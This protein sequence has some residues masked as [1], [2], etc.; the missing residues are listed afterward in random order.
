IG[1][2]PV[3]ITDHGDGHRDLK[4]IELIEISIVESPADL[5]ATI[6]DVKSAIAEAM[7]LKEIEALLRDAG[8][9][10][11]ADATA[12]VSRIKALSRGEREDEQKTSDLLAAIRAATEK[13]TAR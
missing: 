2:R 1:Y 4:E 8:G 6:S 9:F 13:L 3:Q 11:R 10:S 5:G 12:L 7:S